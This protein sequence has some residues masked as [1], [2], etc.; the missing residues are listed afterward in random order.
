MKRGTFRKKT[1]NELKASILNKNKLNDTKSKYDKKT[2]KKGKIKPIKTI[3][4]LR[5]ELWKLFSLY[6]RTR[7][8]FTCVTC[9]KKG[10][11]GGIHA[12]HFITGA[13][14]GAELYFDEKNVHAQCYH[15]NINLSGNWVKYEEFMNE[16]YLGNVVHDLK[17]RRTLEMGRKVTSEWYEEKIKE[18]KLKNEQA[19]I[20]LQEMW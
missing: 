18:Y 14:C 12:G 9:G 15:C 11:G 7:D 16:H 1:Y 2:P 8:N 20:Q 13:T 17:R 4:K 5:K 19:L 3:S 6:I 10:E